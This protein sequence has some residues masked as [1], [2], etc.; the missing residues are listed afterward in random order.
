MN[1]EIDAFL[2]TLPARELD[3]IE[4]SG[5]AH[6]GRGFRSYRALQYPA[7]DICTKVLPEPQA[8]LVFCEQVLEHTPDPWRAVR[9][10]RAMLRPGGHAVISVPFMVR[11]HDEPS[12][13]WR[14]TAAGLRIL[15]EGAGLEVVSTGDWGSRASVIANLWF[16]FPH[17]PGLPLGR[18]PAVPLVVWSIARVP[19]QKS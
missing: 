9:N 15:L 1:R 12:D 18:S 5:W 3:A 19:D 4:I 10:I 8:D 7:F 16:W 2:R 6:E 14:F 17:I 13:Y 11:V